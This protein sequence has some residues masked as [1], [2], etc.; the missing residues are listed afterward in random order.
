MLLIV[1]LLTTTLIKPL[2]GA[3]GL[4]DRKSTAAQLENIRD[5]LL[6]HVVANGFLPCPV[7]AR[8]T[9]QSPLPSLSSS[10][11]A[12]SFEIPDASEVCK[13][14][15]GGIPARLLG[16][17]GEIDARGQ[18]LDNWNRPYR[19]AVSLNSHP[20]EGTQ[21]LPDWTSPGEATRVGLS[22]LSAAITVCG[23]SHRNRCPRQAIR[24]S[25][26]VFVVFSLGKESGVD[27][28]QAENQDDDQEYVLQEESIEPAERYD[29]Q[30]VWATVPDIMYWMLR[31]GWLP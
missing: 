7:A 11:Q 9:S 12:V 27:G 5:S 24:A 30:I 31:S 8:S 29:D 28:A 6:A 19:Y 1:G 13:I 25:N 26:V 17:L 21:G 18:L 4:L 2:I 16:I 10:A 15:Q 14:E 22:E 3:K 23:E 20:E